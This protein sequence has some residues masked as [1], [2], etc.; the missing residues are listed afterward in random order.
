MKATATAVRKGGWVRHEVTSRQLDICCGSSLC[1]HL[2][3]SGLS[4]GHQT[5]RLDNAG[6]W[7]SEERVVGRGL[8]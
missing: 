1:S 6:A 5:P 3:L 8:A 4:A 2:N 7:G